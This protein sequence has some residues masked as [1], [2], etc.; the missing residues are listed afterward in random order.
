[1]FTKDLLL[2]YQ[3]IVADQTAAGVDSQPAER[4]EKREWAS[5]AEEVQ[6]IM[7]DSSLPEHLHYHD[8]IALGTRCPVVSGYMLR[9]QNS[10]THAGPTPT[11]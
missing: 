6:V 7:D 11:V 2:L 1:M 10:R 5:E 4:E 9:R 8:L 3:L